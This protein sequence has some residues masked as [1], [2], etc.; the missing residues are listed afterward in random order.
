MKKLSGTERETILCP[1][2]LGLEEASLSLGITSPQE[3]G[4]RKHRPSQRLRHYQTFGRYHLECPRLLHFQLPAEVD[5]V[6]LTARIGR[7]SGR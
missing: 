1:M 3:I 5:I 2:R 6:I 7:L 4:R